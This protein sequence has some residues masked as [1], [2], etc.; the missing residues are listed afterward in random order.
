MSNIN[1]NGLYYILQSYNR[2]NNRI[3]CMCAE[4]NGININ[5]RDVLAVM[6][7][8]YQTL[9]NINSILLTKSSVF[10]L[11]LYFYTKIVMNKILATAQS[12]S[13]NSFSSFS[14]NNFIINSTEN[15]MMRYTPTLSY[16]CSNKTKEAEQKLIDKIID[17]G[18]GDG[19]LLS[20][21]V[22]NFSLLTHETSNFG[23]DF[24]NYF[25]ENIMLGT[26][27]GNYIIN[28]ITLELDGPNTNIIQVYKFNIQTSPGG[29]DI[30]Y[31]S[32]LI[33]S[34]NKVFKTIDLNQR[35]SVGSRLILI[36]NNTN[37]VDIFINSSIFND[38]EKKY[39]KPIN[40]SSGVLCYICKCK[41]INSFSITSINLE[42]DGSNTNIRQVYKFE[43]QWPDRD[44]KYYS[45]LVLQFC[46]EKKISVHLCEVDNN[47]ARLV[48]ITNPSDPGGLTTI[49]Y[50]DTA[51]SA[52]QANRILFDKAAYLKNTLDTNISLSYDIKFALQSLDKVK[53]DIVYDNSP[54][55]QDL[56][57]TVSDI[58]FHKNAFYHY[59]YKTF[60]DDTFISTDGN[61]TTKKTTNLN[62][63]KE[64]GRAQFITYIIPRPL[65]DSKDIY[66]YIFYRFGAQSITQENIGTTSIYCQVTPLSW[67]LSETEF[68]TLPDATI[69]FPWYEFAWKSEIGGLRYYS[70]YTSY[71]QITPELTGV[72]LKE[73]GIFNI[74]IK[75]PF[76]LN[77]IAPDI[78]FNSNVK[79]INISNFNDRVKFE[80]Y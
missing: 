48:G 72:E 3:Q 45:E 42:M 65:L 9:V 50:I 39:I 37:T 33:Y 40:E 46:N 11:D 61:V 15:T 32:I 78:V 1:I 44:I 13:W 76:E 69:N 79:Q 68:P 26:Q 62:V 8:D 10:I 56:I 7:F 41:Q 60:N 35:D 57:N 27:N 74:S 73:L 34:S 4:Y 47:N 5:T 12:D 19:S 6:R 17:G 53:F 36:K 21:F 64:P 66:I 23:L 20:E 43:I 71:T 55:T 80:S 14:S 49:I 16:C 25:N 75:N 28:K 52:V 70:G 29:T 2:A 38:T 31:N 58:A 24:T 51:H 59:L 18:D 67:V 63:L 54:Y 77:P 22:R 30:D